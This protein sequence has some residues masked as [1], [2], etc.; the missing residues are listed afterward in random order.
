MSW[1]YELQIV[2][3]EEG[4]WHKIGLFYAT[5]DEARRAG[6][7]KHWSWT[8]CADYRV[9]ESDKEVNV[10]HSPGPEQEV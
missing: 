7:A 8:M 6:Q 3:E 4:K 10:A 9:I 2:G 5:E 1:T